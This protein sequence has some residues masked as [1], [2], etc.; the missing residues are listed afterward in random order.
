[1]A[2]L[3]NDENNDY[4]DNDD[5]SHNEHN[6]GGDTSDTLGWIDCWIDQPAGEHGQKNQEG[7]LGWEKG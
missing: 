2:A 4:N 5:D 3:Q 7:R 6:D 1:M